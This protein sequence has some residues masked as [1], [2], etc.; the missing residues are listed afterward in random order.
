MW[1][2]RV[3]VCDEE[4]CGMAPERLRS[5]LMPQDSRRNS[6][7]APSLCD[8]RID[9]AVALS[10]IRAMR[11][12]SPTYKPS[13]AT[14]MK[15]WRV[16]PKNVCGPNWVQQSGLLARPGST[17]GGTPCCILEMLA[18]DRHYKNAGWGPT[19]V[20]RKHLRVKAEPQTLSLKAGRKH[21]ESELICEARAH[22]RS[23]FPGEHP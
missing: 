16:R 14:R 21:R 2:L 7:R 10:R 11:P 3:P 17:P 22:L 13:I 23:P 15:I 18:G 1:G 4:H 8:D 19:I 6:S 20:S 9:P 12:C 5:I